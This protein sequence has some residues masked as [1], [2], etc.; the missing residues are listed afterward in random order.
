MKRSAEQTWPPRP[1]RSPLR[2]QGWQTS[3][4]RDFG[5]FF[6]ATHAPVLSVSMATGAAPLVGVATLHRHGAEIGG[7][8]AAVQ[9]REQ[10]EEGI[11][12]PQLPQPLHS[13]AQRRQ[14]RRRPV[15][16]ATLGWMIGVLESLIASVQHCFMFK[17]NVGRDATT[18]ECVFMLTVG[19]FLCSILYADIVGFTKLASSC[20]P[21]ELV[22]VLNKLFGRFDDIAKVMEKNQPKPQARNPFP[23]G[24]TVFLPLV[25]AEK[26]VSAH[27]D[28]GGLLLLCV[29]TAGPHPQPRQELCSD[30]AG[31][32]HCHQVRVVSV[33][34][35]I[36]GAQSFHL[37]SFHCLL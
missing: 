11:Q 5:G 12:R 7:D 6:L 23:P 28:P 25:F 21:Q 10:R 15:V 3:L 4:R 32:V 36:K 2:W 27:Q 34:V 22:A 9:A 16:V 30:G 17:S 29:W 31:H 1:A 37:D 19:F 26:R 14:V 35:S 18:G 8:K 24:L 33:S 20:S 13:A